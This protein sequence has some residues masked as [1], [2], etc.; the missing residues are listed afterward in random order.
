MSGNRRDLAPAQPKACAG[1]AR[2]RCDLRER[3]GK[4]YNDR[5]RGKRD[6]S[7]RAIRREGSRHAPDSLGDDRD[8][9]KLEAM[10]ETI[11]H[12]SGEGGRTDRKGE[13]DRRRGHGEGEPRGKAA[14]KAVAA[15]NAERKADLAGGRPRQKLA[16]R[17]QVR[18][19]RLIE[20]FAPH[21]QLIAKI[22]EMRDRAAEGGQAQFQE[23]HE[24]LADRPPLRQWCGT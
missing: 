6:G 2:D 15:E 19:S 22:S 20:P 12:G 21:H 11:R 3:S 16:Q 17:N 5:N 24:D 14:P 8:G 10:Q 23:R 4:G 7:T 13:Q 9:D 18:I 1:A